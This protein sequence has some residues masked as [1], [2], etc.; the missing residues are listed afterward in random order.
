MISI[1]DCRKCKHERP[2]KDGWN[3]CYDAFPDGIPMGFNFGAV[4]EAKECNN[5]I[6]F[7]EI[8]KLDCTGSKQAG[9]AIK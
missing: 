4:K 5:G 9:K 1:I 6:G 7:E 3:C 2:L 8:E